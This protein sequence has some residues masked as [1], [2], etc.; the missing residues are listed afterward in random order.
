MSWQAPN[1]AREPFLNLR[2]LVRVAAALGIVGLALTVWNLA[3]YERAGSGAAARSAE[4]AALEER[5]AESRQR[6]A[7][8]ENDLAQRDLAAENQRAEFLNARIEE[9]S[10][11]WN[12]LFDRLAEALPAGVRLRNLS[13]RV[14]AERGV[15]R[16][17]TASVRTPV[18]LQITGE[19]VDDEA[20][21]GFVDALFAHAA[22]E[23]PNLERESRQGAAA[24]AF[25]LSV[26]YYPER[27]P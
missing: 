23:S 9:R 3:T 19:A 24:L 1:L 7:T 27:E 5:I 16:R 4:I 15:G 8:L 6:L 13:P 20:V 22:F 11:S 2:P 10:F 26:T 21:L 12:V 25:S 18:L 17:R 14:A